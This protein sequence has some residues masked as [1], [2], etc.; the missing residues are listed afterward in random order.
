MAAKQSLSIIPENILV[1]KIYEIRGHKV[2]L[3]RDLAELYGVETRVL[4]Q[5]TRRNLD[6]FPQDF[7]FELTSEELKDWRSQIVTSNSDKMG[8]RYKP[9]V[10]TEHGILMLSSILNS[11]QAI[12]VNIQIVRIF[13]RLR[14]WLTENGELKYDIEELKRKMNSQEKNIELLFT[15]LDRLMDKKIGPRKRMGFMHDDL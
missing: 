13:T 11:Q 14:Q 15:Y 10:F 2:M 8:L 3:D 4:K 9:F 12:Q 1:N 6:R 7:M 5:A